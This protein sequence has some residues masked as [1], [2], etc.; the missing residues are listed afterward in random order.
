MVTRELNFVSC[1]T[2]LNMNL[3]HV[4]ISQEMPNLPS[5]QMNFEL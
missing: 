2:K 4:Y 3:I 1:S 5:E